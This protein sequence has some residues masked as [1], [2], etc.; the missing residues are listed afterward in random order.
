MD[1]CESLR[2]ELATYKVANRL[3]KLTIDRLLKDG[4]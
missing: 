1:D 2:L 4:E 3:L